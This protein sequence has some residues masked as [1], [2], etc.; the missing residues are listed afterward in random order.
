MRDFSII[1]RGHPLFPTF[2]DSHAQADG[3]IIANLAAHF[4]QGHNAKATSVFQR[5]A[6]FIF[7]LVD[8]RRPELTDQMVMNMQ[9]QTIQPAFFTA[10]GGLTKVMNHTLDIR[11]VHRAGEAP[12]GRFAKAGWG[13]CWQPAVRAP[14]AAPAQMR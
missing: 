3:I 2:T 1:S 9:F 12:V 10:S 7:P 4:F 13:D 8:F 5:S 14:V 11:M 6:E